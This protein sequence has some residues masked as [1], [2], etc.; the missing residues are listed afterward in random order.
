LFQRAHAQ[1]ATAAATTPSENCVSPREEAPVKVAGV[2]PVAEAEFPGVGVDPPALIVLFEE[3]LMYGDAV[4]IVAGELPMLAVLLLMLAPPPL[5]SLFGCTT[6]PWTAD[7]CIE[8]DTDIA[9]I[10]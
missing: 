8:F 4:L 5:L 7:G 6:P 2:A 1:K 10:L 3:M 9:A